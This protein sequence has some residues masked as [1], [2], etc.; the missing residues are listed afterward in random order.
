MGLLLLPLLIPQNGLPTI[1][2][3]YRFKKIVKNIPLV[4]PPPKLPTIPMAIPMAIPMGHSRYVFD[5]AQ[6]GQRIQ[7]TSDFPQ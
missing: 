7:E 1:R 5:Q 2:G 6:L 4:G 3:S